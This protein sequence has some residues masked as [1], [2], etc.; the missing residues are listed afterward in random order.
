MF[1]TLD[2]NNSQSLDKKEIVALIKAFWN[3]NDNEQ[4]K[5]LVQTIYNNIDTNCD[6]QVT[7]EEWHAAVLSGDL[8]RDL[9]DDDYWTRWAF[10][11]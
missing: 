2:K 10:H 7:P 1:K 3:D 4:M 6:G 9:V 11:V 5:Y 8:K